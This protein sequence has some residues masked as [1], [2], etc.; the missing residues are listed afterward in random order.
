MFTRSK[1]TLAA[2]L[3]VAGVLATAAPALAV[4]T[5]APQV[6]P[7]IS[8]YGYALEHSMMPAAPAVSPLQATSL[9]ALE[10]SL[11][12]PKVGTPIVAHT[13]LTANRGPQPAYQLS[14]T[15]DSGSGPAILAFGAVL[16]VTLGAAALITRTL[17]T[18][19]G[20]PIS[21]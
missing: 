5:G 17:G 6:T 9:A 14:R 19:P 10:H 3:A 7:R 21:A 12:A 4:P 8:H 13:H 2:A 18:R 1:S 15:V 16:L 20:R 11:P